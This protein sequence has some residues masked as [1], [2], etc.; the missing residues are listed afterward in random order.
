MGGAVVLRYAYEGGASLKIPSGRDMPTLL[1]GG[2]KFLGCRFKR[3]KAMGDMHSSTGLSI[4][5]SGRGGGLAA[6]ASLVY[7]RNCSFDENEATARSNSLVPSLGGGVYL[8]YDS[9]G[10]FIDRC[11]NCRTHYRA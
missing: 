5:Q 9:R 6:V 11:A 4:M 10:Y 2:P 1:I 3:N 8:D 7:M